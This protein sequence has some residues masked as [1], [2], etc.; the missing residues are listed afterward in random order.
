[1]YFFPVCLELLSLSQQS[2]S[3]EALQCVNFTWQ[4]CKAVHHRQRCTEKLAL[5]FQLVIGKLFYPLPINVLSDDKFSL[6]ETKFGTA[7]LRK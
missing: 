6:A 3:P 2:S 4:H 7:T 1:M 5:K